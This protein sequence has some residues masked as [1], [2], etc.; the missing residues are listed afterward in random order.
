MLVG[1]R[2]YV[3]SIWEVPLYRHSCLLVQPFPLD[4]SDN[5]NNKIVKVSGGRKLI[6]PGAATQER[7]TTCIVR[8]K[9]VFKM[10]PEV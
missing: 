9:I 3:C 10:M 6:A 5:N 7:V 1:V 2:M 4:K 8:P